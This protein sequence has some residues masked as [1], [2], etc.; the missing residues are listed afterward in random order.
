MELVLSYENGAAR[1]RVKN[2]V[3]E[4]EKEAESFGIG[5]KTCSRIITRHGGTFAAGKDETGKFYLA[6]FTLP[7]AKEAEK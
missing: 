1:V 5:L 6:S 2:G 4:K 3:P 7:V